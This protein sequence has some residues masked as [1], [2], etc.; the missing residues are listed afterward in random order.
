MT[1]QAWLAYY[2][3]PTDGSADLIDS[4]GDGMNNWQ[5]WVAGT[6]PTNAESGLRISSVSY[7]DAGV[8]VSWQSI[9]DRSYYLQRATDLGGTVDFVTVAT[10]IVGLTNTT[11]YVDSNS[12]GSGPF[13]Y[14]VG[15]PAP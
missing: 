11:T 1:F 9:T 14:R 2:G 4:D 6:S 13:F 15:I 5:E 12:I 10:N 8:V 3:L 7:S